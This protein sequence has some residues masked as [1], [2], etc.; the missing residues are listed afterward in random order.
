MSCNPD[1]QSSTSTDAESSEMLKKVTKPN[2]EI[3]A[4]AY[5]KAVEVSYNE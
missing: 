5:I 4:N 2:G 1:L 3:N